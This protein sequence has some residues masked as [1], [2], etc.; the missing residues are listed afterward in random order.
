[1]IL[2]I[3][4][5]AIRIAAPP[6]AALDLARPETFATFLD[7]GPDLVVNAAAFTDVDL[8]EREPGPAFAA[9]R[10]G[11]AALAAQC[12]ERGIPLIHLSTD[13]VF[14]GRKAG[15]YVETDAAAALSVYGR[16]KL[17]GETAVRARNQR[18]VILRCSWVFGPHGPNFVR[19]IV[20]RAARGEPLRVVND[21]RGCPTATS[22]IAKA[23]L[24][25]ARRITG[26][27]AVW[28]TYHYA[29]QPP[30]TRFAF[31]EAIVAEA[32]C[33]VRGTPKLT[34]IRSADYAGPAA[35]PANSVLDS[36]AF[37]QRFGLAAEPWQGPLREVV[38]SIGAE[39]SSGA[40]RERA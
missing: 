16:S 1:M 37:T 13:Y 38:A 22:S 17:E 36:A 33:W 40:R 23:I 4:P 24:A 31:A 10:D 19:S 32:Q 11:A 14:D 18:H 8:A 35:R 27:E 9:N 7:A 25:V 5:S 28:G 20:M 12:A 29:S 34:A 15:A 6:R 21:Q 2:A 39:L 3:A 26:G 30:V